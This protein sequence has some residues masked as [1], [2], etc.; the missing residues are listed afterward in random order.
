MGVHGMEKEDTSK[1]EHPTQKP[2]V[3]AEWFFS[4]WGK[5]GDIVIDIYLGSGFTLIACEKTGRTCYGMEIDPHYCDVIVKRWEDYTGK[6][7][8]TINGTPE[9][10]S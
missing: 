6:T 3:L 1:R 7:A 10:N 5:A 8:E 2:V 9:Q 4:R